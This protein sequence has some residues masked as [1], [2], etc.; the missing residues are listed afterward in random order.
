MTDREVN[1][2]GN[3]YNSF[4]LILNSITIKYT[5][6]AEDHETLETKQAADGYLDSINKR[7]TYYSY[8]DYTV[9][10]MKNA[11]I[12]SLKLLQ[13]GINGEIREI[14]SIYHE[15]LLLQRRQRTI[16][17]FEEKNNYYRMLNGYPDVED[18][19]F[20][21]VPETLT[22]EHGI[23]NKIPLHL[24]QDYYNKQ[25]EGLGDYYISLIE[26]Y[27]YIEDLKARFPEKKYLKYI[28][29]YR[30]SLQTARDAK[31]FQIIQIVRPDTK[32]SLLDEFIQVYEQC[33]EYFMTTIY[34]YQYRSFFEKYDNF[35]AMCIMLMT[36]QQVVMRQLSSYVNRNF[37]DIYAVKA[38]YE[39][40]DLP[41]DLSI[42]E[43]TQNTLLKNL[44]MFIQNKA[45]DKVI[46]DIAYLLGFTNI[47]VYKYFLSKERNMD[48]Y[49]VPIVKWTTKFNTDTGEVEKI[50]DY[51]AMYDLYF[52]RVEIKEDDFLLTFNDATN[53]IKYDD[54]VTD[55]AFW[56]QDQNLLDRVWKTTYNFV[57]SKYLSLGVSYSM[58]D[59]MF[60][61]VLLLKLIMQK[62]D[63][64]DE[65]TIKLP[66]VTGNTRIPIFDVIIA[67]VC[68]TSCKHNLYGEIITVPTQVISVLDYVKKHEQYDMN[69][70]TLKFNY[71]YFFNPDERDDNDEVEEF[72]NQL[73]KFIQ[74][75]KD[76]L[77]AD[78]FQFNFDYF[79]KKKPDTQWKLEQLQFAMTKQ[80]YL[81]F[82]KY[83]DVI[84]QDTSKAPDKIKA[85]NDIY[86]NIRSLKTLLNYYLTRICN[87]RREYEHIKTLYDA[88]FYSEEMSDLFTITG[89][90]T[91]Y[92]RTAYTYFEFLYHRNPL[93]YR[94]L[95]EID[96]QEE[97]LKY[98]TK[99]GK[100]SSV[101]TYDRFMD[102][103]EY[104]DIF[105]DFS[106]FKG[107]KAAGDEDIKTDKIYYYV[108]HIIGRIKMILDDI[109]YLYMIN[110]TQTPLA[111]LLVRLVRF[112]KSYTVDVLGMDTLIVM[113]QKPENSMKIFDEI[114]YMQK[115]IQTDEH[116]RLSY[117]D[118]FHLISAVLTTKEDKI[119]FNDKAL[120]DEFL[121]ITNYRGIYAKIKELLSLCLRDEMLYKKEI[122]I[123]EEN[124]ELIL[125]DTIHV[126]SKLSTK[127]SNK[128]TD[129]IVK[130]W[131]E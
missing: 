120:Y 6:F 85:I 65:L 108:N 1:P 116:L 91:G 66:R 3:L 45:T 22:S 32:E 126:N 92:K 131:Y 78:T 57:E 20:F 28:G 72:K 25:S 12:T 114:Y 104:G 77:L 86:K 128:F 113:N 34:V 67:L 112:F 102:D 51:K 71:N 2:L 10:E 93:L 53:H 127:D 106:S 119:P 43:D 95:F 101:Y 23:S 44:N 40:Y 107:Q 61:N 89:E 47:R 48:P 70:D 50:P 19:D 76:N 123:E 99:E 90:R 103:V 109:E 27:G 9:D 130:A 83:I 16:D 100:D 21:Y 84:M 110:D 98:I 58:T 124:H 129:K 56:I 63:D 8:T 15:S 64:L 96:F 39:A 73:I 13:K 17:T 41:F 62:S 80:D 31:N 125:D 30:I 60:E 49:G 115:L 29:S 122:D 75:N 69:L 117:G 74:T 118:V 87:N 18:T 97:Y 121:Y 59:I 33:R 38:L 42:D 82:R 55:D 105:I 79:D 5:G 14:P 35:I 11:G 52:Q 111:D 68:L 24:I 36:V 81:K 46:Y 88:L 7:D 37:F 54:V 26:G 94:A 4:I